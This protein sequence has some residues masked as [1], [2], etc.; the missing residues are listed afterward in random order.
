MIKNN[1]ILS[2]FIIL[3]SVFFISPSGAADVVIVGDTQFRPVSDIIQSMQRVLHSHVSTYTPRQV[4]GR[5]KG[6]VRDENAKIVVA[7]GKDALEIADDLPETMPVVY[8]MLITPPKTRRQNITGVYMETPI[9]EYLTIIIRNFPEIQKIGV[10]YGHETEQLVKSAES[11]YFKSVRAKNSYEFVNALGGLNIDALLLLP[12]R[13]LLSPSAVE[14]VYLY[15][16]RKKIPILGISEKH[17]KEGSLLALVF[18]TE[19]MGRQLGEMVNA[20][21][22][23]G[24]ADSISQSPPRRFNLYIN[25]ATAHKMNIQVPEEII[26]KAKRVYP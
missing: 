6:V 5:L 22:S 16:F 20:V 13:N 21:F 15:S 12:D 18:D 4:E 1:G 26:R 9:D 7:L 17:V 11:H 24:N 14:A 25:T 8:G 3:F 10:I 23:A 19:N 2:T